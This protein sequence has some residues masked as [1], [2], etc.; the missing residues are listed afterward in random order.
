[1]NGL[2]T[3]LADEMYALGLRDLDLG[4]VAGPHRLITQRCARYIYE[5]R[6]ES[7]KP[8]FAGIRY[9]SRLNPLWECWAIFDSR[10]VYETD[11]VNPIRERDE[12]LLEVAALFGL[13]I[14]S[15]RASSY[16]KAQ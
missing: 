14:E 15:D 5:Q 13:S 9:L 12:D 10:V 4:T 16:Y 2:R 7:G 11:S 3:A 1:M 6:S 8:L